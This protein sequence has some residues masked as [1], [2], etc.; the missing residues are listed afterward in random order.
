[1]LLVLSKRNWG[2]TINFTMSPNF[3]LWGKN[4]PDIKKQL[5][6]LYRYFG[7]FIE[8]GKWKK[9]LRH[10]ILTF[11]MYFLRFLVGVKYIMRSKN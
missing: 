4:D 8:Q 1:M 3:L 11:G 5:G 9:L 10:P 6:L 7:V 2:Y